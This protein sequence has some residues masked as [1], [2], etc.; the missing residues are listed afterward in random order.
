MNGAKLSKQVYERV[1]ILR[2]KRDADSVNTTVEATT[3]SSNVTET[4][5]SNT[6]ETATGTPTTL[7]EPT[8]PVDT[9]VT[10]SNTESVK[11]LTV[12]ESTGDR[13]VIILASVM[14]PNVDYI[15]ELSFSGKIKDSLTGFYKS[16][17]SNDDGEKM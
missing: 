16:T 14:K 3:D 1:A 11:I 10:H 15:L 12:M 2:T 5:A 9:Q 7:L 13:L 17:Y 4:D 8:Q 6:T